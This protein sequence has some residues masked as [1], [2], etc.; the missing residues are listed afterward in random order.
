MPANVFDD[1]AVLPFRDNWTSSGKRGVDANKLH[2]VAAGSP[3]HLSIAA[4]FNKTLAHRR[5]DEIHRVENGYQ[6]EAFHVACTGIEQTIGAADFDRRTMVRRLFHGSSAIDL[7]VNAPTAGFLPL[8]AGA[9]TG[10]IYGD[11]SYFARDAAYSHD[12]ARRLPSGQRQMLV[13]EVAVGRSVVGE[14]GMK[15]CPI[16]PGQQYVRYDSL[17][18]RVQDPTIFVVQHSSQAYPAYLITYH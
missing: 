12:Y 11:G 1:F 2:L 17:V 7:I 18:D 4:E 14:E 3:E 16:I 6:H 9:S 10:A 13:V 8:N 15:M 5:I